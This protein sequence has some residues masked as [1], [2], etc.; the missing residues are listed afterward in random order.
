MATVEALIQR[1]PAQDRPYRVP[2]SNIEAEQ[3]LLGAILINNDAF[4]RVSDFLRSEHFVEEFHRRIF[5]IAGTLIRAGQARHADHAEDL[6]GRAR[7]RRHD[8]AAISGAARDRGDHHHQRLRLRPHHLRSRGAPRADHDRR[9]RGQRRL[10]CAGRFQPA[11]ADRGGRAAALPDRRERALRR[12]LPALLRR[13]ED[14]RRHG[15]QGLRARGRRCP[16]IAT[17]L[18]DLDRKMGGL[19][20]SDLVILAGRPGMGKTAL[21]TNIA[22][23]IANAYEGRDP[24]RR[25]HRDGQ[26]RHRRLLLAGNVGRAAGHPHHRRAVRR[27]L[28]QDPPRRHHRGRLPP[29]RRRGRP[30]CR[31]SPSTSTRPAASPSPSSP[32]ARAG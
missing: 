2:P 8:R 20:A 1:P 27:R 29:D 15:R 6:S 30:R 24:R 21:A 18:R 13:A 19:Q 28:L 25:R 12:R 4:D 16:A 14:R 10:R 26:R 3:A 22:F 9:G 7:P 5:E 11:R 31:R 32:R 17:G 23:N